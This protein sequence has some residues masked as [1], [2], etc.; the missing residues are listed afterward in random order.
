MQHGTALH[1]GHLAERA[2][3]SGD[4][5]QPDLSRD[6]VMALLRARIASL[7]VQA[8]KQDVLP[9]VRT[10]EALAIWSKDYF[11]ALAEKV[12]CTAAVA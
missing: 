4:W 7:D 1:L 11:L 9:F 6:D 3:Q 2:R 10:P 5:Q 8:A 12:V